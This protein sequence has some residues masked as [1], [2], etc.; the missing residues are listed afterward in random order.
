MKVE[1]DTVN[2]T[3]KVLE[4][5]TI[6]EALKFILELENY[7]DYKL[8]PNT[9]INTIRIKDNNLPW[10]NPNPFSTPTNPWWKQPYTVI[11]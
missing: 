3:I 11:Y 1:I 4:E 6:A 8:I 9:V 2:K 5:S 10:V 7:M